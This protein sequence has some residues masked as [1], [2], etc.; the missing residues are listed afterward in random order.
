M[1]FITIE[2]LFGNKWSRDSKFHFLLFLPSS[3]SPCCCCWRKRKKKTFFCTIILWI[4]L[5][6]YPFHM[7]FFPSS[8]TNC[9]S[10]WQKIFLVFMR[11]EEGDGGGWGRWGGEKSFTVINWYSNLSNWTMMM[12][13]MLVDGEVSSCQNE[14]KRNSVIL[15]LNER[16]KEKQFIYFKIFSFFFSVLVRVRV[17]K[18]TFRNNFMLQT[19]RKSMKTN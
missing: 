2:R 18:S 19:S 16:K 5:T 6:E 9:T 3:T 1:N 12:M 14:K 8:H 11:V 15:I 10:L 7:F 4:H 13:A 17:V